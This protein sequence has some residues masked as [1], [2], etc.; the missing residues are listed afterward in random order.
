[1]GV[2]NSRLNLVEPDPPE[3]LIELKLT[4][5]DIADDIVVDDFGPLQ[6]IQQNLRKFLQL[7]AIARDSQ[8]ACNLAD[9]K[10][11]NNII[12]R[13]IVNDQRGITIFESDN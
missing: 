6:P 9:N 10:R 11:W 13:V 4:E 7:L 1:M 12:V 3:G 5:L 2:L 8:A